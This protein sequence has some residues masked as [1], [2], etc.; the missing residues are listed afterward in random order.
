MKNLLILTITVFFTFVLNAQ[1]ISGTV[2]NNDGVSITRATII[3]ENIEENASKKSLTNEK[4]D[5]SLENIPQGTYILKI[6]S[7]GYDNF[8]S[9]KFKISD[10]DSTKKDTIVLQKTNTILS[11]VT[12][13]AKKPPIETKAGKTIV[14][15]DASPS[16]A[17]L[18]ALELLEKSPGVMVDNDGNIS[19]KGKPGVQI[20]IDG[21]PSYL[22]GNNLTAYLKS[23]SSNS[24][25][26][27]EIMTNPPAKYDAAGNSGIINIKTKKGNLKGMNASLTFNASKMN[28]HRINGN[29]NFNYRNKNLNI[30]GGYSTGYKF[31]EEALYID[32]SIFDQNL[33]LVG[34]AIQS[35]PKSE[36]NNFHDI[37]IG[38]DYSIT[39]K[40]MI[41]IVFNT[42]LSY[43]K[44]SMK[45]YSTLY[46]QQNSISSKLQSISSNFDDNAN[47]AGNLNYKHSFKKKGQE[48][49]FDFDRIHYQ[50]KSGIDLV[51]QQLNSSDVKQG[52]DILMK[53]AMPSNIDITSFKTDFSLP[54]KN[55]GKIETGIKTS[56]VKTDNKVAYQI[57][58]G[59][60][61]ID[62]LDRSNHFIYK[63]NINAVYIDYTKTYK[64][65]DFNAGL[66]F[67]ATES[68]GN[69]ITRDSSFKRNYAN[70]FPSIGASYTVNNK[71]Q[72][73]ISYNRRIT[74]P[75]YEN[76]NPFVFY[77]DSLTYNQGNPFL[78]PQFSNNIEL[79]HAYN[80]M[81][82]TTINYTITSD[83][84]T[85]LLK[86]VDEKTF[87]TNENFSSMRQIGIA[88]NFNKALNKWWTMNI[89]TNVFNNHYEGIYTDGK[90]NYPLEVNKTSAMINMSN[91]FTFKKSW[92]A[93]LSGW[94]R[95]AN[96]QGILVANQMGV[97]NFNISKKLWQNKALLK[98]GIRDIFNTQ[99]FNGYA[100]YA[101][102]NT[103]VKNTRESRQFTISFTMKLGKNNI[104]PSRKRTTGAED[105]QSRA[106]G[107][108]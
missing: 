26:Q 20:F 32:R 18:S 34:K 45:S 69:Q 1:K 103:K 94:Y 6:S 7:I 107:G 106:G 75:N 17:G 42:E 41:G 37:K 100:T 14:N 58:R 77:I 31:V 29:T 23:L 25:D 90:K 36:R 21:K 67:E 89:F 57:N 55:D 98:L 66:R 44:E 16:N 87:Q 85:N 78:K 28:N 99:Q 59:A 80:K 92:G 51:T 53:G 4:G 38:A 96:M 40:D 84:I 5:Y 24:L 15:V 49:S 62:D 10:K 102:V 72:F 27:L 95:S 65:W 52:A 88:I 97:M 83:I 79:A 71:N 82:Q 3:L 46:N 68:K 33:H 81:L 39:S 104:A 63:E 9:P 54:L 64:K 12:V 70:L 108:N 105:E 76:L 30:F 61:W 8:I 47:V 48:L 11:N 43:G 74:R 13:N 86:Q 50:N 60:G 35:V 56:H 19:L 101:N 73:S 22:S 93:E 91:S 2:I